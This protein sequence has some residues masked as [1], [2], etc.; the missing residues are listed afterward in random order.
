MIPFFTRVVA[1][2]QQFVVL[3]FAEIEYYMKPCKIG[4]EAMF[5]VDFLE[6]F[7]TELGRQLPELS[8]KIVAQ[9][10]VSQYASGY[11]ANGY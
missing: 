4:V 3:L 9:I 8:S 10:R 1:K 11:D 7:P 6:R 2:P 5:Q